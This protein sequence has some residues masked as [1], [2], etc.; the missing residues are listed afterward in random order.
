MVWNGKKSKCRGAMGTMTHGVGPLLGELAHGMTGRDLTLEITTSSMSVEWAAAL[1]STYF[2]VETNDYSSYAAANLCASLYSG[3]RNSP[4]V[5]PVKDF[6]SFVTGILT[7][8]NDA[9]ILELDSA[10][11]SETPTNLRTYLIAPIL[12]RKGSHSLIK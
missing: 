10:L 12:R 8:D 11:T 1:R 3:V 2:P 7:L 6:Q 4:T 5:N 9:P